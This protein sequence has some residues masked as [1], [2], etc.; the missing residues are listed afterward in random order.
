MVI[1]TDVKDDGHHKVEN[2]ETFFSDGVPLATA[3]NGEPC[4]YEDE[5]PWNDVRLPSF[6]M[7][8]RYDIE[9]TPN[10]TTLVVKGEL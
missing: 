10:L 4:E 3:C 6:I 1:I 5:F 9:L 2:E 8:I 7:P